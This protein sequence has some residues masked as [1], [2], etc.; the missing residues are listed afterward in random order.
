MTTCEFPS[1][2]NPIQ[3]SMIRFIDD[4]MDQAQHSVSSAI[5]LCSGFPVVSF[6]FSREVSMVMVEISRHLTNVVA[7]NLCY[8]LACM[9]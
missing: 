9:R 5:V 6:G 4:L 1:V 2:M 3:E 8:S 7:K